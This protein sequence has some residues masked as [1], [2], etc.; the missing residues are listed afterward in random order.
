MRMGR[1]QEAVV[2]M[3]DEARRRK[4]SASKPEPVDLRRDLHDRRSDGGCCRR[5]RWLLGDL[6]RAE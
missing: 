4:R 1:R 5:G 2:R 6:P 3:M